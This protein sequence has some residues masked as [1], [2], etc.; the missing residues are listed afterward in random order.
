ML[1]RFLT[2]VALLLLPAAVHAEWREARSANFLVYSEGSETQLREFTAKLEKFHFVLRAMH[3]V[4]RD[5]PPVRL[6]VFLM[7]NIDGVQRTLPYPAGGVAGY[8]NSAI[9]G[10]ALVGTR[11]AGGRY[12]YNLDPETILLHEYAHHF[13]HSYFPATY[14]TWYVEGFAEFWGATRI[15][16]NDVVEV[17]R[18]ANSRFLSF[19][20]N[21]W[22]SLD[23][24]L[25]ARSYADVGAN[26][27]LIYAEGWL[28]LRYLFENRERSGQ[29]QAYLNAINGGR[30]Y[31]E[32][33]NEAFGD[34]ARALNSELIDYSGHRQFPVLRVPFRP[35]AV[36][37]I[38]IR[39]LR[40]AEAELIRAEIRLS[41]GIAARQA[42]DFAAEVR[43]I[44]SRHMDD[45]YAL[46]IL[47]EAERIGGDRA[48]AIA[49][50]D[51]LL[52]IEPENP[53]ALMRRGLLAAETLAGAASTDETA[54][55][56][57]REPIV[58]A[59]RSSPDDPLIL[60]AFYDAYRLQGRLPPVAAQNALFR[61]LELAPG[62]DDL[63]YKVAADFEQRHMIR[64][65]V[66]VIRPTALA[67]AD[68]GDESQREQRR[69]EEREEEWREAGQAPRETAREMLARLEAQLAQGDTQAGA[70]PPE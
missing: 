48:A 4:T 70:Q 2:I 61:A 22:V 6:K 68:H 10:P 56:A 15:L 39:P 51:R 60:E 28:L 9:R 19:E 5:P 37:D 24:I 13:M 59:G 42:R 3:N 38:S 58:R 27:D 52:S 29:L 47:A 41:Q 67:L 1:R 26:V 55:R 33:M 30:S 46:G 50:N 23:R 44:A 34:G 65:A 53:R 31:D 8:Y 36:G 14:P 69:R 25:G 63:R 43:A 20:G 17:G 16:E 7:Q 62:D 12:S 35:I 11:N 57:A 54:W 49:A 45:P 18:P 21:R 32:A 64:E 66:Y 40:P